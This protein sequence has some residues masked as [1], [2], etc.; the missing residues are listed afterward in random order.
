MP[1]VSAG[2]GVFL[3]KCRRDFDE[4]IRTNPVV[5][6]QEYLDIHR[7][8]R[9]VVVGDGVVSAYWRI[10]QPGAFHNNLARGGTID[11]SGIPDQ[12]LREVAAVSRNLGINHAGFDVAVTD[13]GVFILELNPFFGTR[14]I[15]VTAA[16]MGRIIHHYLSSG[17]RD[18]PGLKSA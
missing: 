4:L 2:L 3:I 12:V 13:T 11:R 18:V 10:G 15:P 7:D 16:E 17:T 6:V 9:V 1:P 5:Y 14:D 8:L